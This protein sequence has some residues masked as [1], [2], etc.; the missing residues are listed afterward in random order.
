MQ[1]IEYYTKL[2]LDGQIPF[3]DKIKNQLMIKS[4]HKIKVIIEIPQQESLSILENNS[5]VQWSNEMHEVISELR[6]GTKKYSDNEIDK[7]VDDALMAVRE[8]QIIG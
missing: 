4:N 5:D 6:N 7:I 2:L 1:R 3:P 8:E